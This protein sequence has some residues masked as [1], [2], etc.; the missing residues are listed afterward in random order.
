MS[1]DVKLN[2]R[3]ITGGEPELEEIISI[4]GDRLLRYATS[5]LCNHHDAEDVV[6]S[7]FLIAYEKRRNFR[8]ENLSAWLY[9]ITYTRCLNHLKRPKL[10]FMDDVEN[11]FEESV[12]PFDEPAISEDVQKALQKLK[13]ADRA[14]LFC[15]IMDGQSYEELSE[16][17]NKSPAALR[18]RYERAKEK[19]AGYLREDFF[20]KEQQNEYRHEQI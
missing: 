17:F 14:L 6:S 11:I 15:R 5:I 12:N 7:V 3:F 13:A 10:I 2:M 9:R 8:G 4:F 1:E 20:T 18:K 16:I 19:L